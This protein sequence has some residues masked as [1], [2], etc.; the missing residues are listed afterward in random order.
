MD[1]RNFD[2]LSTDPGHVSAPKIEFLVTHC[3]CS[4]I[5][6]THFQNAFVHSGDPGHGEVL[7]CLHPNEG[8]N[9][10]G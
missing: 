1:C 6:V 4:I 2:T 3:H 5:D 9:Y 10:G 7:Y 8:D